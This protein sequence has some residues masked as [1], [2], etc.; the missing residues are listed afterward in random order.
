MAGAW[1]S[2]ELRT[3]FIEGITGAQTMGMPVD[4]ADQPT[5]T[6]EDP[7]GYAAGDSEGR[8]WDPR[9]LVTPTG[10][11]PPG[12]KKVVCGKKIM[13]TTTDQSAL[14]GMRPTLLRL[15]FLPA[16][17]AEVEDFVAVD[18]GGFRYYRGEMQPPSA[19]FDTAIVRVDVRA[20]DAPGLVTS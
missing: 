12:A 9:A 20:P 8:P 13:A 5:F 6:F 11:P 18:I 14:G 16:A 17:W 1:P 7:R 3:K 19:L 2:D 4:E 10:P 15:T